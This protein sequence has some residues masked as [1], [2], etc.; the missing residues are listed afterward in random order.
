[1]DEGV[2]QIGKLLLR[3]RARRSRFD[4]LVVDD[5]ALLA[6]GFA[7]VLLPPIMARSG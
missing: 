1:V 5:P 2:M 6:L 4:E 7:Y 3:Q